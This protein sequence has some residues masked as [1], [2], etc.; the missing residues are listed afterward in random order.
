MIR[1]TYYFLRHG[2]GVQKRQKALGSVEFMKD[3]AKRV[4]AD[5]F[6]EL[7][8]DL[9]GD[10]EGNIL[11]I[12]T[13]TGATF[14]YYRANAKVTAIEPDD[15]FRAA[16]QEAAEN[17][18]AE[19][20][21]IHGEG[22]SLPFEDASFD[23][24]SAST[25]LCCVTSPAKTLKEFKRILRPGGQ[26]RL[27]EH[28]RSEHWL[29]GPMMD[30]FNPVWLR[31]NKLGCNLNRKTVKNVRAAGFIIRSLKPHKIYS[32]AMPTAFPIRIIKAERPV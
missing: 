8:S 19:I 7:R 11:E 16:A 18:K 29:A 24:V 27:L 13:G 2:P 4:D 10:L 32:T 22:E 31:I 1:E 21:V 6:A 9:V 23:A 17:A 14:Q 20:Q 5:G 28:I 26:V 15:E 25:V 12:G 30:L 3:L